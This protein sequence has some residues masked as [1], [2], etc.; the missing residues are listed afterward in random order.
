MSDKE[1]NGANQEND[2]LRAVLSTPE[3][4]RV[5]WRILDFCGLYRNPLTN[6]QGVTGFNCGKQSVAQ[7]LVDECISIH[8]KATADLIINN[9]IE[10]ENESK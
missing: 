10:D 9:K 5:M 8:P 4:K 2:D 6:D 7:W 3:G 1:K